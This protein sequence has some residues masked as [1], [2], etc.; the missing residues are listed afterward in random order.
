[1]KACVLAV[2]LL[3]VAGPVAAAQPAD[4]PVPAPERIACPVAAA[5]PTRGAPGQ[6][7]R[8]DR[9]PAA[10][11]ELTV[12]KSVGGCWVSVVKVGDRTYDVP[13]GPRPVR[14]EDVTPRMR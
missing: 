13:S 3:A 8:L 6:L 5:Q 12:L 9:L 14:R 11:L 10:R 4:S 1:M 7:R 2:S